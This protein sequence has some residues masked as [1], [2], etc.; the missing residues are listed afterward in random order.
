MT[1]DIIVR[2]VNYQGDDRTTCFSFPFR[3]W[4]KEQ[5]VVYCSDPATPWAETNITQRTTVILNE[6]NYGGAVVFANPPA[7]GSNLAIVREGSFLQEDEYLSGSRF[8]A[9]EIEDRFDEDAAE[10]Q[11][12]L[13]ATTRSIKVPNSGTQ[14]PEEVYEQLLTGA[15]IVNNALTTLIELSNQ[16]TYYYNLV[17]GQLGQVSYT[18]AQEV[19]F[20]VDQTHIVDEEGEWVCNISNGFRYYPTSHQLLVTVDGLALTPGEHFEEI[21]TYGKEST[22]IR[23]KINMY[24]GQQVY[25]KAMFLGT[26]EFD[27]KLWEMDNKIDAANETLQAAIDAANKTLQAAIDA[28]NKTLQATIDAA[29]KT[30]QATI[31]AANETLQATIGAANETL[32]AAINKA[33]A[34][35][36]EKENELNGLVEEAKKIP[37]EIVDQLEEEITQIEDLVEEARKIVGSNENWESFQGAIDTLN[38]IYSTFTSN[39]LPTQGYCELNSGYSGNSC[40][41]LPEGVCYFKGTNTLHLAID[42]LVLSPKYFEEIGSCVCG[43][44]VYGA[45]YMKLCEG[46][47]LYQ[48]QELHAW[49]E[50]FWGTA[51]WEPEEYQ[52]DI[53]TR[54]YTKATSGCIYYSDDLGRCWRSCLDTLSDDGAPRT[55]LHLCDHGLY[56]AVGNNEGDSEG[57]GNGVCWGWDGVNWNCGC[58]IPNN[59]CLCALW[60]SEHL[61][62]FV[63]EPV[64]ELEP[65]SPLPEAEDNG[66]SDEPGESGSQRDGNQEEDSEETGEGGNGSSEDD[67]GKDDEEEEEDSESQEKNQNGSGVAAAFI[68]PAAEESPEGPDHCFLWGPISPTYRLKSDLCFCSSSIPVHITIDQAMPTGAGTNCQ[69]GS[70]VTIAV[71]KSDTYQRLTRADIPLEAEGDDEE[72]QEKDSPQG[73]CEFARYEAGGPICANTEL[74]TCFTT[75][76]QNGSGEATIEDEAETE[77]YP[78]CWSAGYYA[79]AIY[80]VYGG[81]LLRSC[82]PKVNFYVNRKERYS[83]DAAVAE[84]D[85]AAEAKEDTTDSN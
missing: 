80:C 27:F 20:T 52:P 28:A 10:R 25:I 48:G 14:T 66:E 8:D 3:V 24:Q 45:N 7:S 59:A 38:S 79:A 39:E 81:C 26:E 22:Q 34:D 11:E 77:T 53:T 57:N 19:S 83:S 47:C 78:T 31:G 64:T 30:L 63:D 33:N 50:S 67:E 18:R 61:P 65:M 74:Y 85:A 84:P 73:W 82:I 32:Q 37:Q 75:A 71:Y 6:N 4:G 35:F 68:S 12:L 58:G 21:G 42:G 62:F 46:L 72:S 36:E 69:H 55:C 44:T 60:E 70:G 76:G 17:L 13:D 43:E 40:L 41:T 1:I 49:T 23:F 15:T 56:L 54:L 9:H 2:R 51:D 16:A 29:N 5:V